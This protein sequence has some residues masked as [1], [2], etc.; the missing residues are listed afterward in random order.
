MRSHGG[1]NN[2]D[3]QDFGAPQPTNYRS[4]PPLTAP[5]LLGTTHVMDLGV[6]GCSRKDVGSSDIENELDL[7]LCWVT[8]GG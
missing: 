5:D 4:C 7:D 3:C 6:G 2:H 1:N 8:V